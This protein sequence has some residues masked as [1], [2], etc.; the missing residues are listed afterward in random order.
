MCNC[1][2]DLFR[3]FCF[4]TVHCSKYWKT[5]CLLPSYLKSN[6]NKEE[7][8]KYRVVKNRDMKCEFVSIRILGAYQTYVE[9]CKF[10]G[11]RTVQ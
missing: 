5:Q 4:H 6:E 3:V 7:K 2:T 10:L 9:R 1:L 8:L 11:I